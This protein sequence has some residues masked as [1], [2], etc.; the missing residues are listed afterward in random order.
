MTPAS[1]GRPGSGSRSG[2]IV[3]RVAERQQLTRALADVRA[4]GCRMVLVSG[5][6]GIGK[7]RMLA[8]LADMSAEA[9]ALVLT[10]RAAEFE[11]DLP[12]GLFLDALDDELQH[13]GKTVLAQ[14]SRQQLQMLATVFPAIA[15]SG[16]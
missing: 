3:G 1:P 10:G 13:S 8:E 9:G 11:R 4:G 6:P 12:F 7:T 5:D 15:H 16:A 14:L 2:A